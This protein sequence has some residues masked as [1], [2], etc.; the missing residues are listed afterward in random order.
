MLGRKALAAAGTKGKVMNLD[1]LLDGPKNAKWTIALAHGAGAG[2]ETPFM[3]AFAAGL[4]ERGYRVARF[5]FLYMAGYRKTGNKK[6]PD[7]EPVLRETWLKVVDML[8]KDHLVIGGKSMGGRIASLITDEAGVAGLVCLGYP[9][10]PTG[11]PER[12]RIEH[13]KTIVTKALIC[14]GTRDPFGSEAEVAGFHLSPAIRIQW[15]EDGDHSFKP[16]KSSG[17]TEEQNWEEAIGAIAAFV[18][19]L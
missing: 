12:L 15:L 7:R 14:Q 3:N 19:G 9:F 1:L 17:R 2:M 5:E 6:P 11:K 8:G 4:A 18:A 13:L 16:R 10:H